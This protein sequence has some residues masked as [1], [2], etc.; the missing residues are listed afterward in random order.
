[1]TEETSQETAE[2]MPEGWY[3]DPAPTEQM[4]LAAAHAEYV[5]GYVAEHG[6]YP[7]QQG[8]SRRRRRDR[9]NLTRRSS[10]SRSVAR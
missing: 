2:G 5:A 1:M 7:A 4:Q 3:H 9:S 6:H 8:R 10:S